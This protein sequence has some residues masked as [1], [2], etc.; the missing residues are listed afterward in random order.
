M[1]KK[2][3]SL[4]GQLVQTPERQ[5]DKGDLAPQRRALL[6]KWSKDP[7]AWLTGVDPT[8]T[9]GRGLGALHLE[10]MEFPDGRPLIWTTDEKDDDEPIKPF[11]NLLYL[12]QLVEVWKVERFRLDDKC[13][14]M[15]ISTL[16]LQ[17]MDWS[18]KFKPGRRYL[19]SRKKEKD[20]IELLRDKIRAV[21]KRLPG[22]IQEALLQDKTPAGRIT[23]GTG[24]YILGVTQNVAQS[25]A[26]GGT[27]SGIL[28]DEAA[29]QDQF[30]QIV[31][32]AIPMAGRLWAVSTA[33][34]GGAGAKHFLYLRDQ[35]DVTGPQVWDS[36]EP[37]PG[38]KFSK[39]VDD[40]V[41]C[42]LDYEADPKKRSP[43]WEKQA[44]KGLTDKQWRREY[45]HDWT[46]AAGDSFY[47]EW[48][49]NGEDDVYVA[50]PGGLLSLPIYRGW[51]FGR[52]TPA[53]LWSQYDPKNDLLWV[54]REFQPEDID[55]RTY[56]DCVL[57]LSSQIGRDRLNQYS[58]S[59]ID[60]IAS[61][62]RM[63]SPPWI[64]KDGAYAR[65]FLDYAGPEANDSSDMPEADSEE[66][67][68]AMVLAEAGID[69]QVHSAPV[70]AGADA[71]RERLKIRECQYGHED[72]PGHPGILFT[73]ACPILTAGFAGGIAYPKP[74]A[75]TPEPKDPARD[76][77]F[78]HLHE[79]L[80]R[81]VIHLTELTRPYE[82]ALPPTGYADRR[83]IEPEEVAQATMS[84]A[85]PFAGKGT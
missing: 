69:L 23:Y 9:T 2:K 38:V 18:C 25:T 78:E 11:P 35:P 77:F 34:I 21:H 52:R 80:R 47:P 24:S 74:T 83:R 51:D 20:A 84:W 32:A 60:T 22:W 50:N 63:P 64:P 40:F 27:A 12:E 26:R 57:F 68:R 62:P 39:T 76:G 16:Y 10:L 7:W 45:K 65:Q 37:I 8:T 5:E 53:C 73:P 71:I 46:T 61:D 81:V 79:C 13:R 14:Q 44:R 72:C 36:F 3:S 66:R 6:L 43:E 42:I 55:I 17:L 70:R 41:V 1:K 75:G 59:W 67:T 15:L 30:P 54:L 29:Y 82:A 56:R 49:D 31:Q 28:V 33:D 58:A 48:Q 85:D 19:V 4:W